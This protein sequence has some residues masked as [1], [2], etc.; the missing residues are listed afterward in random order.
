MGWKLAWVWTEMKV[1]RWWDLGSVVG[2]RGGS[3]RVREEG[4]KLWEAARR[5]QIA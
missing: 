3:W 4:H 2:Q 5:S 1:T